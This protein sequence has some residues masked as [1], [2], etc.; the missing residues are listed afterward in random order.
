[1]SM[2]QDIQNF[3]LGQVVKV[4][5]V[6]PYAAVE[7]LERVAQGGTLTKEIGTTHAFLS[8]VDNESTNH[9]Y[10]SLEAA[11]VG[12]IAYKFDG[13]NSQATTYFC[14]MVGAKG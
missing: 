12:A 1:M 2:Q 5:T 8:Y 3:W 10:H 6:G 4:H 14:K 13:P 9:I 7:Y 11:I